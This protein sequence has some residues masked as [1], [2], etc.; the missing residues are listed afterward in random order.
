MEEEGKGT[1]LFAWGSA[2]TDQFYISEEQFEAKRPVLQGYFLKSGLTIREVACGGQHTLILTTSGRVFSM[3]SGDEGQLGREG[4][5]SVPGPVALAH[6]VDMISAGEAHSCAANSRN[7]ILYTWGVMRNLGGNMAP[8]AKAPQRTGLRDFKGKQFKK[9]LSGNNHVI[10]L[11]DKKIHVWGDSETCVLGRIPLER[12]KNQQSLQVGGI[13]LRGVVDV[14]TGGYHC[15]ALVEKKGKSEGAVERQVFAWGKNN[16]GQLGIGTDESTHLQHRVLGLPETP[17]RHIA[18][19][20]DHTLFLLENGEVYGCGRN[21]DHQLGPIR[22]EDV[23]SSLALRPA[24]PRPAE[25]QD[26]DLEPKMDTVT[27]PVKLHLAEPLAHVFSSAHYNIAAARS[28]QFYSWGL[29]FSYVLGNGRDEE[30][31]EPYP[32]KP[33]FFKHQQVATISL[34]GSHVMYTVGP[35][36]FKQPDLEFALDKIQQP[37]L[38]RVP[39][40]HRIERDVSA[41]IERKAKL[42]AKEAADRPSK[43]PSRKSENKEDKS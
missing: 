37:R 34:G 6:P 28:G 8:V 27:V 1:E 17:V 18:G 29:G 24:L 16:W 20:E 3:G 30:V 36:A 38:P 40:P 26:A 39:F 10:V 21:D 25:D 4:P 41:S 15:F 42:R 2:E 22:E 35:E 23:R 13:A 14:F 33:E 43:S 32:I 9:L 12:R 11:I 31:R 5:A 19:G 7:G